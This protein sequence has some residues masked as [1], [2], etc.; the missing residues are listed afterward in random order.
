MCIKNTGVCVKVLVKS[1]NVVN[2]F[3][4]ITSA[5]KYFGLSIRTMD[6]LENKG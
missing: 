1:N 6:R 4:T 5:A 3:S 2:T